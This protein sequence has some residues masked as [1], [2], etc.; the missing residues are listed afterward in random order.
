MLAA[1]KRY[2]ELMSWAEQAKRQKFERTVEAWETV[3]GGKRVFRCL[4]TSEKAK[5][6][7]PA[8]VS[9]SPYCLYRIDFGLPRWVRNLQVSPLSYGSA[10]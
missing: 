4:G 10:D 7:L 5:L 2:S 8:W 1:W 3:K 9:L 6:P